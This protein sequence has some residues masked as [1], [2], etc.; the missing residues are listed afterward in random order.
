MAET[1]K[2]AD[3]VWCVA[4]DI[5]K[6]MNVFLIEDEGGVTMF[7]AGTRGMVKPIRR[8]ADELGGLRRIVLGHGHA[9]HR[10][11]APGL[12]VPVFCHPDAVADAEGD[13]GYHTFDIDQIPWWF[14]RSVYPILLK[15]IWDGGPVRIAGTVSEGDDV[16]GFKVV[17]LPGHA[18]G[19]IAL[20]REGDGLALVSDVVYMADSIRLKPLPDDVAPMV[21][22]PVWAVDYEQS[23]DSVRKLAALG[24]TRVW[25]GHEH[26]I[27]GTREEVRARLERAADRAAAEPGT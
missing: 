25:P 19:L 27:E 22:H 24:A 15:R 7:D 20:W 1:T 17:H 8:A 11:S 4:G 10:G 26:A 16:A 6:A 23:I 12:G 2:I 3:G 13:G 9:D 14:S 5:K 21:P 18:A